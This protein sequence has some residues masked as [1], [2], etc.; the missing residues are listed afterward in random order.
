MKANCFWSFLLIGKERNAFAWS[1][2]TYHVPEAVSVFSSKRYRTQH[3][4]QRG[5]GHSFPWPLAGVESSYCLKVTCL[6]KL[7]SCTWLERVDF[8]GDLLILPLSSGVLCCQC[9]QFQV[10]G[11]RGRNTSQGAYYCVVLWV[12]RF[13]S[14]PSFYLSESYVFFMYNIRIFSGT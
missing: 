4:S 11:I 6:V 3:N 9:L 10:W 12:P 1:K 13:L 5:G 2:A 8:L 7:L 14:G